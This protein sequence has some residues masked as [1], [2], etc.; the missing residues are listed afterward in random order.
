MF[1]RGACSRWL[2]RTFSGYLLAIPLLAAEPLPD[3]LTLEYALSLADEPHPELELAG[4]ALDR[5]RAGEQLVESRYKAHVGLEVALRAV[6]PSDVAREADPTNNDS[7][8][9]LRLG[10]RLYDFGRSEAAQSAAEQE[11]RSGEWAHLAARQQRRLDIMARYFDV[12]LADLEYTKDNEAMA[13]AFVGF[14]K[15]RDR[16]ELG[17]VSDIRML[18]LESVYQ[19]VRQR[20]SVSQARQRTARS[21]LAMAL[22]RPGELSANLEVPALPWLEREPGELAALEQAAVDG[23]PRLQELRAQ[24]TAA[25]QR[26]DAELARRKGE[27]RGELQAA[28]YNRKFSN[29]NPFAAALVYEVPLLTGGTIDAEAARL[30]AL[31]RE[32]QALAAAEELAIRQA[33]LELWLELQSLRARADELEVRA[34]FRDLYLDR[35]RALYELEVTSDL[36]DAMAESSAVRLQ[37]AEN[38]F[39]TALAWARLDALTG[40]LLQGELPGTDVQQGADSGATK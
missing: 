15:A 9:K 32:K 36:G 23:N 1:C 24:A 29:N 7:W 40:H 3:P 8:A 38:R 26:V 25:N 10:K 21:R 27:L 30:R 31:A 39:A 12:I 22:N 19:A 6:E 16:N 17:K 4:A 2:A 33:V 18:E 28:A 11:V 20:R 5:A 35:S 37:T 14:D 13:A 34:K